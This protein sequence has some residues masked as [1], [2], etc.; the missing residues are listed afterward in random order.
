MQGD[1]GN[2]ERNLSREARGGNPVQIQVRPIV[3][4][5]ASLI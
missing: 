4:S 1:E 5:D 2:T 3:P